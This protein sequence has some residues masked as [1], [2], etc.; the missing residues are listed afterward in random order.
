M[1]DTLATDPLLQCLVVLTKLNNNPASAEAL[2]YGLP[3][4]PSDEKQRLFSMDRPKANFS[5]AAAKAGFESQLEKRK[6]KDIPSIVLPALS[7]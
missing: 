2:A 7:A 3:F 5:R 6:L 4:D 1:T